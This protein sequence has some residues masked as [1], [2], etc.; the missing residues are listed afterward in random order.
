MQ[1][2]FAPAE[3]KRARLDAGVDNAQWQNLQPSH[4]KETMQTMRRH[5][6]EEVKYTAMTTADR[7]YAP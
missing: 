7:K 5:Q 3:G 6:E 1:G 4:S 2:E